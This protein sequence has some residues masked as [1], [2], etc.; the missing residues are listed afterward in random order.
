VPDKAPATGIVSQ[1]LVR[2]QKHRNLHL[3]RL[4]QKPARA[5]TQNIRQRI[6]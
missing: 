4:R 2:R 6:L 5:K 1:I 3:N